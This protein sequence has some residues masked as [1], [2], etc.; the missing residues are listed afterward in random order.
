MY[1]NV[2]S[3]YRSVRTIITFR[4]CENRRPREGE[5]L[6]HH[7]IKPPHGSLAVC[8]AIAS[9]SNV[10][11]DSVFERGL[12]IRLAGVYALQWYA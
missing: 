5:G 4:A 11:L 7:G 3:K 12:L 1:Q 10:L 9:N 8:F 6:L 2:R